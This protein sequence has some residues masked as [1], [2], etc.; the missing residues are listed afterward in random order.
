MSRGD[1]PYG[2]IAATPRTRAAA[3]K[4]CIGTDADGC[5]TDYEGASRRGHRSRWSALLHDR[6]RGLADASA[7]AG[8]LTSENTTRSDGE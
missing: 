6:A 2:V 4:T 8:R 1:R 5:R 3:I 7:A